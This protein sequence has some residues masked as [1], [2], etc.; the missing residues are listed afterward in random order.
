MN[1]KRYSYSASL[2][3]NVSDE[4]INTYLIRPLAGVF[5]RFFFYTP[6]TP[7]QV[8]LLSTFAGCV[9]AYFYLD[10]SAA[11]NVIA[12]AC[13]T[14]KD[15]LDSADGQLARVK[16]QFSRSG[17]FLD[18]LGDLVVNG[19]VFGAITFALMDT[20]H[21]LTT[22]ALGAS[23][24]LGLTLRVSYH[25]FYQTSFLHLGK[26]Y[27]INRVT[28]EVLPE[29][30]HQ[31]RLTLLLQRLFQLVYGWQDKLM[32][33]IDAWSRHG[34]PHA[35]NVEEAW[36]GDRL[37]LRLSGFLGLGTEL[38]LLTMFSF[39]DELE[40]YMYINVVVLNIAWGVSIAYRRIGLRRRIITDR[41]R[42]AGSP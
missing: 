29:D 25:V 5:V 40:L 12:G 36:Y 27:Q 34:L 22:I 15:I 17:R 23:S 20:P 10:G 33:T 31:E 32:F 37:A 1:E 39:L 18:S 6:I 8:T 13:I 30:Q 3:S 28:E 42:Q 35:Q 2:K 9:A 14:L 11:Q 41:S 24:L 38:F 26:Q 7:N 4:V 19:I 21:A 16:Q